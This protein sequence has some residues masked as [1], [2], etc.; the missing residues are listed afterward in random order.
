MNPKTL[1]HSVAASAPARICLAG[2]SLDWMID[3]PSVVA[4]V[5]LRTTVRITRGVGDTVHL[6]AAE[7]INATRHTT[8]K[9]LGRYRGD[10]MDLLQATAYVLAETCA[11][12]L[13]GSQ[14]SSITRVPVG[15]GVSSSAAVSVAASAALLLAG[16]NSIPA[17]R[18]VATAAHAAEAMQ[19]HSG[20]GWMDFLACAYGGVN[21][22][23]GGTPAMIRPLR[24]EIGCPIIL[25]D[26]LDR[27]ATART[28]VGK[29]ERFY[30]GDADLRHYAVVAPRIVT[31]LAELLAMPDA[32]YPAIGE[33]LQEAQT[34]LRERVRCSTPI[35]D[36]CVTRAV[37]AGAY[38]A[39]ITGSGHGGC[40]FALAP[41]EMVP[42]V[43]AALSDLP[44]RVMLFT[45]GEPHGV[46]ILP[47]Q[48]EEPV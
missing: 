18:T 23:T 41:V 34:L 37:K 10:P 19:L 1:P 46:V 8:V 12:V 3:G 16:Q 25:I 13:P 28:L 33:L 44:V 29:H 26:T 2:E 7:P 24:E 31:D 27:R 35:I 4:A 30:T 48:S 15:A 40:L 43:R 45:T 17:P 32:D 36:E 20:A 47:D 39:K 22:L 11:G 9:D 14:I 21:H 42:A 6:Q 5:P 38:G